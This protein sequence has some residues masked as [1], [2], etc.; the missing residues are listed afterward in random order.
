MKIKRAIFTLLLLGC[1]LISWSTEKTEYIPFVQ[2]GKVWSCYWCTCGQTGM[3]YRYRIGEEDTICRGKTYK[4]AYVYTEPEFNP[5]TAFCFGGLREEDKKVYGW[6]D[7]FLLSEQT[8]IQLGSFFLNFAEEFSM[9]KEALLYDFSLEEGDRFTPL[10]WITMDVLECD[11]VEICGALR[12]RMKIGGAGWFR[13]GYWIEGLGFQ[14][15][16]FS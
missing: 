7:V 6:C 13:R 8:C 1:V 16:P 15:G 10:E 11:T 5:A 9:E 3:Y 2:P 12:K 14:E 4:K